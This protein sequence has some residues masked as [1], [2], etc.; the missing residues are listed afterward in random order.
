[1]QN[2][3]YYRI[4]LSCKIYLKFPSS[5]RC[6]IMY[7]VYWSGSQTKTPSREEGLVTFFGCAHHY[8]IV[9]FRWYCI[10]HGM[11]MHGAA[12]V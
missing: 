5:Y 3:G 11:H 6:R 9:S 7:S 2:Y 12:Q 10:I 4:V 8:V 1:M